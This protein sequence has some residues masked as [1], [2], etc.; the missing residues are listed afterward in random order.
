MFDSLER[1]R[2]E[3][4]REINAEAIACAPIEPWLKKAYSSMFAAARK[5]PNYNLSRE[6]ESELIRR[7]WDRCEITFLKFQPRQEGWS[8]NPYG[9][10]LDRIES[11]K[12][13]SLG[14][15]RIVSV[16]VNLAMNEWGE[17]VLKVISEAYVVAN[18][19]L[20]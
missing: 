19:D 17:D 2:D 3:W 14:N 12:G 8:R 5:R 15:C 10:S 4:Q 6:E 1:Q 20:R 13:Y 11:S 16:A 7:C 18:S 9:P